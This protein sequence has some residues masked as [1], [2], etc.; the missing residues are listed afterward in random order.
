MEEILKNLQRENL[1]L[2]PIFKRA[3]AFIIDDFLI[4]MIIFI[5]F[6][7]QISKA[8]TPEEVIIT[9]NTLFPYIILLKIIYQTFFVWQYG[10][11]LGKMAVKIRVVDEKSFDN[12]DL[13]NSFLRAIV[14]I[15]SES[16]FY[17]GF[18]WGILS[19]TKQTWHD[20][21]AKSLVLDA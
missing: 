11:T 17:L 18:V 15:V 4:S 12:L 10:A 20:K 16:L 5:A 21:A 19:P 8:S 7:T 6:Y 2:S 14:R 13:K 9:I 1:T 3:I